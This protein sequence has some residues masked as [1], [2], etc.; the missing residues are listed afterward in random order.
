[1]LDRF[2]KFVLWQER[3]HKNFGLDGRTFDMGWIFLI[4]R[5]MIITVF[6]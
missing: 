1:M 6:P 2:M 4:G 5:V 3:L